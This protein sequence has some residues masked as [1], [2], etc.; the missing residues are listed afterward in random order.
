[1][2][3]G[4]Q[5]AGQ[6]HETSF[7][8]VTA[9]LLGLPFDDVTIT[10]GDTDVVSAGGGTHSGR[11]M[12]HASTV[13]AL[14][15]ED[16]IA[17]GRALAAHCLGAQLDEVVFEDGVFR[18]A[19]RNTF[20]SWYDLANRVDDKN[21]PEPLRGG[22]KVRRDN[23][24][25]TPVFPNGACICEIEIDPETGSLDLVRYTTVDDVG[26]CINPMIVHGQT[27]GGIAQGV[28]QAM[29][30]QCVIDPGSGQPIA[31]SLMDYGMPRF[32]NM[33][34]FKTKIVEVLSP[35]NPFGVKAGG[36]GGT[37][38]APAVIMSAVE[39]ALAP[40][41]P[42]KL[43]LPVTALKVWNIIQAGRAR[44]VSAAE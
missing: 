17:K 38:P 19:D 39:D 15:S 43:E 16:L 8:Q 24:M 6:G 3:I 28:G 25:H 44:G 23:E 2:V 40:Y 21:L 35:T 34:S 18:V 4:T 37:T 10:L 29:W 27:H 13:L 1:V 26:R 20:L 7:A 9:D 31:G 36:E 11:S 14:A 22:L 12:R 30:E 41:A 32:D 5:P 42:F 33:P